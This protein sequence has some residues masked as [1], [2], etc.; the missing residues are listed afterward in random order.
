MGPRRADL[1]LPAAV[2]ETA[3]VHVRRR[4][5]LHFTESFYAFDWLYDATSGAD[6]LVPIGDGTAAD[7]RVE[8]G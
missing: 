8:D 2:Q 7:A 4:G 5:L 1:S 3:V 6:N